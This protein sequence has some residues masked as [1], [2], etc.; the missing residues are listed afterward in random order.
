MPTTRVCPAPLRGRPAK[1][2]HHHTTTMS[3]TATTT[4]ILYLLF[5]PSAFGMRGRGHY[6]SAE[7]T[8]P[9]PAEEN[10]ENPADKPAGTMAGVPLRLLQSERFNSGALLRD[11]LEHRPPRGED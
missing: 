4:F 8:D 3:T 6:R 2:F 10:P 9:A 11:I 7:A 1:L 5:T